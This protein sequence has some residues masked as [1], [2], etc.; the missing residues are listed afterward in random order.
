MIQGNCELKLG[1]GFLCVKFAFL[2]LDLIVII[3]ARALRQSTIESAV[4]D[5]KA[6]LLV[7]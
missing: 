1:S 2:A 6:H 3:M 4:S 5:R 7:R